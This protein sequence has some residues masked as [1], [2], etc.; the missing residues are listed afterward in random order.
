MTEAAGTSG[1][2][3]ERFVPGVGVALTKDDAKQLKK[4]AVTKSDLDSK[5]AELIALR[6]SKG[7]E[8]LDREAVAR[9]KQLS[10]E[11]LLKYKDLSKLG[12][13][14]AADMAIIEEIIPA[15]PLQFD[16]MPFQE[17]T[18]EKLKKLQTDVNHLYEA[19][20]GSRLEPGTRIMS[21]QELRKKRYQ[22]LKAKQGT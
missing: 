3:R 12:V 8:A 16:W 9:G 22:E 19:E 4:V 17:V 20:L 7:G 15:D 1:I 14:S 11:L 13:L 10:K 18:M 6:E 5:L 21:D 2:D